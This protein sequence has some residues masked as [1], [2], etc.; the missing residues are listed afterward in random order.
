MQTSIVVLPSTESSFSIHSG[1]GP[2]DFDSPEIPPLLVLMEM[3]HAMEGVYTRL[4]RGLGLAYKCWLSNLTEAGLISLCILR[5]TNIL[6]AFEH[7]KSV[8]HQ[9]ANG[10]LLFDSYALEGAKSSVIFDIADCEN[11]REVAAAQSFI[12]KVLRQSKRQKLDFFKAV[13]VIY[14]HR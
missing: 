12:N 9:L 2:S 6:S 10:E 8:T 1:K 11:T 14:Q 3:L 5:S 7:I 13:Q 4:V